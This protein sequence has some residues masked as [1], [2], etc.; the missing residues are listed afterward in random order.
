V[1]EPVV[2]N[3]NFNILIMRL[4]AD[5]ATAT[6]ELYQTIGVHNLALPAGGFFPG[7]IGAEV[8]VPDDIAPH[9][10]VSV[11]D[12]LFK[13]PDEGETIGRLVEY[14]GDG[15]Q[16]PFRGDHGNVI[17]AQIILAATL[18]SA[19]ANGDA[20][21]HIVLPPGYECTRPADID[22]NSPW[23]VPDTLG[24]FGGRIPQGRGTAD[25]GSGTRGWSVTGNNCTYTLPQNGVLY[26][27]SSLYLRVTVN[28]PV[29]ALSRLNNEQMVD[30]ITVKGFA[31]AAVRHH[32]SRELRDNG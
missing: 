12:L 17:Y 3:F 13:V 23:E 14:Y 15:D 30:R 31:S 24:V 28:N 18:Y 2:A 26:A 20:L 6:V 19:V 9:Y 10:C 1:A 29:T 5:M 11:G 25:D 8:S 21:L 7:K 32:A 16:S 27:G 22:G 4:P